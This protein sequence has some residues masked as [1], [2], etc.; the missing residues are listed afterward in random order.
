MKEFEFI[1]KD[2]WKD[3]RI[4]GLRDDIARHTGAAFAFLW[5]MLASAVVFVAA[6]LI[7]VIGQYEWTYGV[8]G[9]ASAFMMGSAGMVLKICWK[10]DDLEMMLVKE[11]LK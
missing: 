4:R 8:A 3:F 5:V 10:R 9:T 7:Y 6:M 1:D 2:I 11:K